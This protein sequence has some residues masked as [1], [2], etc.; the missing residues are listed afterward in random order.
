MRALPNSDVA[1]WGDRAAPLDDG[2][3]I[4][5]GHHGVVLTPSDDAVPLTEAFAATLPRP[6]ALVVPDGTWRQALKMPRRIPAL[7]PLPRV[8][9]PP[10]PPS[11][12]FL[13]EET[14]DHGL[15]T[16]EA[17]AR[18]LGAIEGAAVREQL[19]TLF[20]RYVGATLSTRGREHP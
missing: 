6:V 7:A 16:F 20:E 4:P 2:A 18:A 19:E 10:G 15:A 14:H 8:T 9:L 12:Y 1:I 5:D 11:R 13:R 17:I 3:L